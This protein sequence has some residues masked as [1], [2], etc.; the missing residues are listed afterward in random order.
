M[1]KNKKDDLN[2]AG[3]ALLHAARLNAQASSPVRNCPLNASGYGALL[4]K[5]R[6]S[7]EKADPLVDPYKFAAIKTALEGLEAVE[8]GEAPLG[9]IEI[10]HSFTEAIHGG[11]RAI[12]LGGEQIS[13]KPS[14]DQAYLRAAAI[15]LWN[16]LPDNRGLL[17]KEAKRHIG[18][19]SMDALAKLVDNFHQ[20]HD[21]N[22]AKS[23]SPLSIHITTIEELVKNYGYRKLMHFV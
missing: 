13:N 15:V 21:I 4:E 22:I 23:K 3:T 10:F 18:I 20:R 6:K 2:R 11:P 19:K 8:R 9:A 16:N 14:A 5:V 12:N 17:L 7:L 1:T